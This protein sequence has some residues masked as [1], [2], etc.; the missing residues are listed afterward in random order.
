MDKQN[1]DD[2]QNEVLADISNVEKRLRE[3]PIN[4]QQVSDLFF[5]FIAKEFPFYQYQLADNPGEELAN[6][7]EATDYLNKIRHFGEDAGF[8]KTK[9]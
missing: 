4:N 9:K 3:N 5:L 2:V 8:I 1:L 6:M 7:E